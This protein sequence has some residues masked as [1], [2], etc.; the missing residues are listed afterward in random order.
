[1]RERSTY[2]WSLADPGRASV[3]CAALTGI[4]ANPAFFGALMQQSPSAAVEFAAQCVDEVV[5]LQA[6]MEAARKAQTQDEPF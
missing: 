5:A 4:T 3:F 1:M 6:R 2:D